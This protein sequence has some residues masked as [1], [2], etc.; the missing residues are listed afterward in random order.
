MSIYERKK[1]VFISSYFI[2][3]IIIDL[4][5]QYTFEFVL[6]KILDIK[7]IKSALTKIDKFVNGY[8]EKDNSK[9]M[10]KQNLK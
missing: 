9:N 10:E 7:H 6:V 5:R 2:C 8:D 4:I 1:L 3:C